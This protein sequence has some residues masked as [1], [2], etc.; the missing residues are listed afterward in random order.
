MILQCLLNE[1][2]FTLKCPPKP[3]Q[4]HITGWLY[5]PKF[6]VALLIKTAI[7][8][9]SGWKSNGEWINS[10]LY[11]PDKILCNSQKGLLP[12][13]ISW[14]FLSTLHQVTQTVLH[15][16]HMVRW[17]HSQVRAD[18]MTGVVEWKKNPCCLVPSVRTKGNLSA[19]PTAFWDVSIFYC[20]WNE[21]L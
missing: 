7:Q 4:H 9:H 17:F 20:L 18:R 1:C 16:G 6:L 19:F 15:L 2:L 14:V 21:I 12:F 10:D 5:T 13:T 11:I 3:K 8:K